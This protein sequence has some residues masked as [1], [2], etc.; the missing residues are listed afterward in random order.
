M[1]RLRMSAK[2]D[3]HYGVIWLTGLTWYIYSGDVTE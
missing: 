3:A 1:I 2:K